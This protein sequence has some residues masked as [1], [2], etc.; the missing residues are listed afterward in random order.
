[1]VSK[2]VTKDS[3]RVDDPE[4]PPD[5]P[6]RFATKDSIESLKEHINQPQE[7]ARS[8]PCDK[9]KSSRRKGPTLFLLPSSTYASSFLPSST[10]NPISPQTGLSAKMHFTPLLLAATLALTSTALPTGLNSLAETP[11]RTSPH[12]QHRCCPPFKPRNKH[13][14]SPRLPC[15]PNCTTRKLFRFDINSMKRCSCC[16]C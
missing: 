16:H 1:M 14:A 11:E 2:F 3:N 9:R 4:Q 12:G 8:I 15:D 6:E 7:V 10:I 5:G 13:F